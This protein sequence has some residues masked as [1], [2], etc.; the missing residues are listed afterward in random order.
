[1]VSFLASIGVLFAALS[2]NATTE[3]NEYCPVTKTETVDPEVY[4]MYNGHTV[5]FCCKHCITTFLMAP[6][7]YVH[8]L[9]Q[10]ASSARADATHQHEGEASH[11][12]AAHD[13]GPN[14]ATGHGAEHE[15]G[16]DHS[17]HHKES[18]G[19]ARFTGFLGK[20]HPL[21]VHF[22]ICLLIAAALAELMYLFS[23]KNSYSDGARLLTL[24]GAATAVVA[25]S[26]GWMAAA[27]AGYTGVLASV[28]TI[29]RWLG[30]A[31]A[32]IAVATS[33]LVE[34]SRRAPDPS[35]R[36]RAAYRGLLLAGAVMVALTGHYGAMLIYGTGYFTW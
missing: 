4:V 15:Q 32:A 16:H 28:L 14:A 21:A 19:I 33:V 34:Y 27:S 26:L 31:T 36:R 1:M 5:Y 25:A 24:V 35:T 20:F 23:G 6:D 12:A 2:E 30:T 29:H 10:F 9:P 22:P 17:A 18:T 7:D 13:A 8:N 11:D 3:F